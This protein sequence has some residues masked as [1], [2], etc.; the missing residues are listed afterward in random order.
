M[1]IERVSSGS[2]TFQTQLQL[3]HT[4]FRIHEEGEVYEYAFEIINH[5]KAIVYANTDCYL[6]EVIEEFLFYSGFI[7]MIY[8]QQGHL[9]YVAPF[10]KRF[11]VLLSEIQPS[12]LYINEKKLTELATWVK[13]EEDII[14]PV[15]KLKGQWVSVDG[16]TR[17]KLAQLLDVEK[18]YVYEEESD[19]YINDFVRFC[20][21]EQKDS[22]YDL[23]IISEMEYE[24]LWNQ[25]CE[26]Y[27]KE[28]NQE[29]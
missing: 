9:L 25:F 29:A 10:K 5:E 26:N 16:H 17:L 19:A 22:I 15:T 12:Q 13:S 11:K 23:P 3:H 27:F 18:V 1:K 7:Q 2:S 28:V 8:D 20:Q 21:N 6:N 24:V 14:I 4:C